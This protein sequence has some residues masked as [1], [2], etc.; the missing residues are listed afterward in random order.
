M[1]DQLEVPGNAKI[2]VERVVWPFEGR[3]VWAYRARV[4]D[5]SEPIDVRAYVQADEELGLLYAQDVSCSASFGEGR[6]FGSI[7]PGIRHLR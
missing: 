6:V 1:R 7:P 2:A 4:T 3:G 5:V